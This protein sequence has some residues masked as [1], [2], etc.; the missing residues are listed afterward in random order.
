M[1][2]EL[3]LWDPHKTNLQVIYE[4]GCALKPIASVDQSPTHIS[5]SIA[6]VHSPTHSSFLHPRDEAATPDLSFS[7]IVRQGLL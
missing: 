6:E 1:D 7:A 2:T 5:I 4:H 3:W